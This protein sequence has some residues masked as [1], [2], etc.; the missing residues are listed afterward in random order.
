MGVSGKVDPEGCAGEQ[1]GMGPETPGEARSPGASSVKLKSVLLKLKVP[2][3]A[4]KRTK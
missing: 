4:L 2:K 3:M 1:G